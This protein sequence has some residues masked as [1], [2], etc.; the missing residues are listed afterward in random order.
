MKDIIKITISLTAVCLVS[1]VILG[2]VFAKTDQA[3]K[4]ITEQIEQEAIQGLLGFGH[5]KKAPDDLKVYPVYRY[6][7]TD[8]SGAT[9][10][11]YLLPLKD[12]KYVLTEVDLAGKAVKV[13]QI[14]ADPSKLAEPSSRDLVVKDALPDGYKAKF[15]DS[16]FIANLGAKR[17]GYVVPGVTQGFKKAVKLM[18]SFDPD[19]TVTG[20]AITESEEDPGLGDEIKKNQFR[21]QFVGKTQ[22]VLK[23]LKVVKEPLPDDYQSVLD[24][25]K[26]K[27]LGL[28]AE[29]VKEVKEK[30]LKDDIYAL[31]GAT[32]SSRA[33]LNGVK[34]TAR[35]FVYR[36]GIVTDAVKQ[37]N[38]QVAF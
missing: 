10:L 25:E 38:I 6:V 27:K 15:E 33:V 34:D 22:D 23:N 30:H 5:G 4:E 36:L 28:N 32:I 2:V 18:V 12:K 31:T 9:L 24:P 8:P 35:K 37:E 19:F 16:V 21:N 7:L 17:L 3:R 14:A 1:A 20:V 11:G 29:Q 26:A 13:I